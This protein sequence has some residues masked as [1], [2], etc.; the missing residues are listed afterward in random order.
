MTLSSLRRA[1]GIVQQDVFL[2]DTSVT[3]NVAYAE[4]EASEERVIEAATTAHIHEYV[5]SL[6]ES[7]RTFVGERG[8]S[9]SGGQRQRLSIARGVVPAP[10]VLIFDDATSAID[11]A[12]EHR[13]RAALKA[14]TA[15]RATIIIAHRLSSLMDADEILVL[16]RGR[17][18][19]RGTHAEL[20]ARGGQYA[21]LYRMQADS[22][23]AG[24]AAPVRRAMEGAAT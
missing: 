14:A 17:V 5:A 19:E 6:P 13:L 23:S 24:K 1:V 18:T 9:L 15:T 8:V 20:L 7:Y 2:F 16:D 12:T 10:A 21:E 4:P 22:K 11:A 3:D